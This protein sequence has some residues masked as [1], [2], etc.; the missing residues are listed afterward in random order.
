MMKNFCR[1]FVVFC[2]QLSLVAQAAPSRIVRGIYCRPGLAM[3]SRLWTSYGSGFTLDPQGAHSGDIGVRCG[4]ADDTEAQGVLQVVEIHQKEARPIVVGGWARLEGVNGTPSY[5]C[6]VYVDCR[7]TNGKSWPMQIAVFDPAKTGWQYSEKTYTP[8]APIASARVYAFLREKAGTAWFDDLYLSEVLD[9]TGKRSANLLQSP[10][11]E[12]QSNRENSQRK[13]FFA[14]LESMNCNAFHFYQ[15]VRWAD[16]AE[17][18]PLAPIPDD[19]PMPSFIEA[20][21]R[22]GLGVWLTVGLG[23]PIVRDVSSPGFPLYACVNNRWGDAYTRAVAHFARY[24]VD[25]IGVVPDEWTYTTGRLKRVFGKH[26]NAKVAAHYKG[27]TSHAHCPVCHERFKKQ[28]GLDFPDMSTPWQSPDPVWAKLLEFRYRETAAWMQRSIAAAKKVNPNVTTD[29]MICVLPVCSDDR[30]GAGAAWD[31]IGADTE[32]DCLQTD[33]YI[34]LHNYRGDSTH[35]YTSETA[36]HLTAANWPRSSGVTLEACRLRAKDRRLDPA[37]VY[38]SALSCLMHGAREFFWWHMT[39][40][41]GKSDW[42]DAPAAKARVAAAYDVMRRM[43]PVVVD[44]ETPGRILVLYSRRSEDLWHWLSRAK[45]NVAVETTMEA[46]AADDGKPQ[47][48]GATDDR[49][50][51]VAHKNVLNWLMRRGYPFQTTFIERPDPARLQ[52]A[53]TVIVPFPL[54]LTQGEALTVRRLAEKGRTVILLNELAPL[55]ESGGVLETPRLESLFG[56]KT[57]APNMEGMVTARFGAGRVIFLGRNA[58][59]RLFV[60]QTPQRDR[61]AR[62]SLA[63][64]G[65]EMTSR[66][67]QVIGVRKSLFSQQPDLDVEAVLASGEKG[68]VLLAINWDVEHAVTVSFRKAAL[69][70][71]SAGQGFSITANGLVKPIAFR[72]AQLR[73][74]PQQAT[75]IHLQQ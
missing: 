24:K 38:G 44:A 21:H 6:S 75:M 15:S 16:V 43:E 68:H 55:D 72:H 74:E 46:Q 1:L 69:G 30:I 10:G 11:F 7:L 54:A 5:K 41:T 31:M 73:L 53:E 60:A 3:D 36:I 17:G 45:A 8:P 40:V 4:T 13:A 27:L 49:R 20:C 62:V 61:A 12:R 26:A 28:Y 32:L 19:D 71:K 14:E 50:G 48:A 33:P 66:L 34:L 23:Y 57:P 52:A 22:R 58:A 42:V 35:Y 9:E 39:H 64:F 65:A 67:D 63:A 59:R 2:L 70:G 37:E 56:A 25:G 18:Q 47:R 29:T 51:F